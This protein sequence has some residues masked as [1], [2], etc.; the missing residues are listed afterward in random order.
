MPRGSCG[1][2]A[3]VEPGASFDKRSISEHGNRHGHALSFVQ[4]ARVRLGPPSADLAVAGRSRRSS[5][6]PGK[7]VT[8]RRAAARLV[9]KG[10]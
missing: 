5:P 10:L 3:G 6:G 2:A 7:P 9:R 8:W 1:D 4:P